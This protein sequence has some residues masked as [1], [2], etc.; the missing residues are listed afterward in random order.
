[1]TGK[2]ILHMHF[3]KEG[4]A[5]RFFVNLVHAFGEAGM[6]QRFI[7]RPGRLWRDEIADL[8][9]II[10]NHYRRLDPSSLWLTWRV[11]RMVRDWRPDVIMA[12]MSRS[13]RLIPDWPGAVKLT[14][15]GD[16]P[17]HL[18][19]FRHND[20]IVANTPG[21]AERCRELGWT[22]PLHVVSNFAR[23]VE[24]RPVAR[25]DHGTPEDAFV[26]AGSGRF[27]GR[28]GFD[29][30][31]RAAAAVPG[32]WLWLA[33]A[34]EREAELKALAADLGILPRTRFFGWVDEPMHYV[35]A[36]DVYVM[37]SRH[38][39][40]G[41]VILEAWHARVPV[42]ST[43]S[44]GPSWFATD[45]QDALMVD[46]DDVTAMAAAIARVREEPGLAQRLV[47]GGAATLEAKFTRARVIEHYMDL[48]DGK[49]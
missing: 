28:K 19:H 34:G 10:E 2:K 25:A 12:W 27:V 9:P 35:A 49:L 14:R 36:A 11:R 13:S 31:V 33:G 30:L 29:T 39:P 47:A 24:V 32:A 38:E 37:P 18:R 6:E 8:G 41:N 1:M 20:V 15:L 17:R 3:G 21:I 7:T 46:I 5:E 45:G 4:G 16:Y 43:R 26:I 40:L 22:R 42:V 23:Q 48:F 44:E